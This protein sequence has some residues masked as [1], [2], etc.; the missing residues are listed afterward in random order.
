MSWIA[1]L[2]VVIGGISGAAV[3][4]YWGGLKENLFGEDK[5]DRVE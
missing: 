5:D 4:Y 3:I 1:W 2:M